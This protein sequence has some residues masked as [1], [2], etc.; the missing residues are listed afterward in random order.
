MLLELVGEQRNCSA[1]WSPG[2]ACVGNVHDLVLLK[3]V[4][5]CYMLELVGEQRSCNARWS[6]GSECVGN[7]HDHQFFYTQRTYRKRTEGFGE[8]QFMFSER[9]MIM[10]SCCSARGVPVLAT[11]ITVFACHILIVFA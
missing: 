9:G 3:E 2:S 1:R 8:V 6:P 10:L 5:S 4:R 11:Q 7:V